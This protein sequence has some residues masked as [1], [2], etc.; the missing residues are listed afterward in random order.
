MKTKLP[1]EI[2]ITHTT[3]RVEAGEIAD[4]GCIHYRRKLIIVSPDSE[5]TD[6]VDTLIHEILHGI[7]NHYNIQTDNEEH[8]V[9]ALADGLTNVFKTNPDLLRYLKEKL[10]E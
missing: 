7:C 2:K 10:S 1:K 5:G 8:I 4:R 6:E 9:T 3:Y